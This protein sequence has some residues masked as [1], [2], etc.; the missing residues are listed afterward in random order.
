MD[1]RWK[2]V[3]RQRLREIGR[4]YEEAKQAY[5][6]GKHEVDTERDWSGVDRYDLPADGDGNAKLV[7]RR[8]A[9]KRAIRVDARG[10]PSC[11]DADHPDCE[12][13]REDIRDGVVETW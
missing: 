11:F 5:Q 13:C 1:E 7:C 4:R 10:R 2:H 3:L 12:G 9:D 8:H 6:T